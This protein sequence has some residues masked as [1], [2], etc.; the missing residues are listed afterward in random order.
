L[1]SGTTPV[2]FLTANTALH[3][4]PIV[5]KLHSKA[6]NKMTLKCQKFDTKLIQI[7]NQQ[8]LGLEEIV[9]GLECAFVNV[10]C[11]SK[12][13]SILRLKIDDIKRFISKQGKSIRFIL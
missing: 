2:E 13:G 1:Y 3:R 10:K 12:T 11:T 9:F 4:N 8:V 7:S 6:V 5:E